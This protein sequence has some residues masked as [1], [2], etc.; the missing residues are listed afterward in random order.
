MHNRLYNWQ[1]E[2]G[3]L[4]NIKNRLDGDLNKFDEKRVGSNVNVYIH[5]QLQVIMNDY[6]G[7]ERG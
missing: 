7:Y 4:N 3:T 1:K 6:L 2:K 5:A